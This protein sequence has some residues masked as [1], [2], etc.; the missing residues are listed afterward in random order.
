MRVRLKRSEAP[1]DWR[2]TELTM[3]HLR[4]LAIAIL[5]GVSCAT[6][7]MPAG[8]MQLKEAFDD[9]L[10][11]LTFAAKDSGEKLEVKVE[12]VSSKPLLLTVDRGETR[13]DFGRESVTIITD[14][15]IQIDLSK[16]EEG[17]FMVRQTGNSRITSGA[18]TWT[19]LPKKDRDKD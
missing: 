1:V 13:F 5:M 15:K 18:I 7:C 19:K 16:K 11:S 17:S 10:V 12:R 2:K 14:S 4:V 6:L 8:P 3:K 9:G